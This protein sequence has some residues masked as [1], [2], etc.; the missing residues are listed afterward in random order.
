MFKTLTKSTFYKQNIK[1]LR[2]MLVFFLSSIVC[3]V[4]Y[5]YTTNKLF[6]LLFWITS[7]YVPF[8]AII[9]LNNLFLDQKNWIFHLISILIIIVSAVLFKFPITESIQ[10]FFT[11]FFVFSLTSYLFIVLAQILSRLIK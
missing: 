10:L 6:S 9:L 11:S 3:L 1:T 4:L 8:S 7:I 5:Q 2:L